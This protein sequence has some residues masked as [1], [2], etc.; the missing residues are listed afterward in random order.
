MRLATR[1]GPDVVTPNELE[2]EELV[3]HEFADD[4]D[5]SASPC[6]RWWSMGAREAIMTMP[7]GCLALLGDDSDPARPRQLCRAT[8]EPL[9]P[10]SSVGSGDAFLA[11]YVA[12]RYDGRPDVGVPAL[13]RGLRRGVHPALRRRG[14]GPARGGT[15]CRPSVDIEVAARR[16]AAGL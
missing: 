14:A 3:G 15:A 4:E 2:A 7:D 1:A 9:E 11:G 6:G 8:L 12:A 5:R 13:R 16:P 10:V